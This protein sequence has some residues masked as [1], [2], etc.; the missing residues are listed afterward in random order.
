MHDDNAESDAQFEPIV[1]AFFDVLGFSDRVKQIGL[2]EI[3]RNMV[4]SAPSGTS[5]HITITPNPA[6][7]HWSNLWL[8]IGPVAGVT[9]ILTNHQQPTSWKRWSC[10]GRTSQ[11]SPQI[12]HRQ[13]G[14]ETF[15]M[16]V[17]ALSQKGN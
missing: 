16:N 10:S 9:H 2:P 8:L 17:D 4:G 1:L 13:L 15:W 5:S 7:K 6:K 12:C 3:N 11:D 14:T